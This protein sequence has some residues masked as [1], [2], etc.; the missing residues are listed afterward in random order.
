MGGARGRCHDPD[1]GPQFPSGVLFE[2][3][4]NAL[5][6]SEMIDGIKVV[7]VWTFM[8]PNRGVLLRLLDFL[9]FMISSLIVGLFLKK[10]DVIIGTSPQ[11]FTVVSAWVLARC[12]RCL[13]FL[14]SET[15]G[16]IQCLRWTLKWC[17]F[18]ILG[19]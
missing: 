8:V 2:G 7:R 10:P 1:W 4:Q 19:V 3:Y 11:F 14:K 12:K 16:Q 13:S 15:F 9:S 5:W 6:Q 17:G 18:C